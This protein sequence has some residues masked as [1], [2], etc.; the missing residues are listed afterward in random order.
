[1]AI[2]WKFHPFSLCSRSS[3]THWIPM[4]LVVRHVGSSQQVQ[5]L[6][7]GPNTERAAD[8]QSQ[9]GVSRPEQPS[10]P[11]LVQRHGGLNK[12]TLRPAPDHWLNAIRPI[13]RHNGSSPRRKRGLIRYTRSDHPI[14]NSNWPIRARR[15]TANE[16]T[17]TT[18]RFHVARR[19]S[20]VTCIWT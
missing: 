18:D 2:T 19:T 4:A 10:V 11:V 3:P 20:Y 6:Q 8:D 16:I 14:C 9:Q 7:R 1:M 17:M 5:C 13:S 12:R 15:H